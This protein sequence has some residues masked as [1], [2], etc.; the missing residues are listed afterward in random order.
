MFIV[1]LFFFSFFFPITINFAVLV[2][3]V[4]VLLVHPSLALYHCSQGMGLRS[5]PSVHIC[6]SQLCSDGSPSLS[7][8]SHDHQL[9]SGLHT[10]SLGPVG[11]PTSTEVCAMG[12][13]Y[14]VL[15]VSS[16]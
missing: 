11:L 9:L 10:Q 2:I 7:L 8:W 1:S 13:Y 12:L 14:N 4:L 15:Y 6:G 5:E 3:F 16:I